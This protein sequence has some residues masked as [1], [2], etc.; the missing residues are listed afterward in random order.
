[1]KTRLFLL[2]IFFSSKSL[3]ALIP[4]RVYHNLP[5]SLGL[6]YIS[7]TIKVTNKISLKSWEFMQKDSKMPF[8]ILSYG[9]AG[10]MSYNLY[11]AKMFFQNGY[12]VIMYD[13]RGFGESSDFEMN[14]NMLYYKEFEED[15]KCV[16]KDTKKKHHPK[17]IILYGL[18]MGNM[19]SASVASEDHSVS[20]LILD[21]FIQDPGLVVKR[22]YS[23]KKKD[24]LLPE[25]SANY[26]SRISK[27][28]IPILLFSGLKDEVTTTEDA[29][30]ILGLNPK[31][32]LVTWDCNHL[33]C[34]YEMTKTN[35]GDL[36]LEKVNEFEMKLG[37][38]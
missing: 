15:L 7:N 9:D 1:M 30:R 37:N 11:Q 28:K 4:D 33:K 22:I 3:F 29:K 26:K 20:N 13:Y 32:E 36:Y 8:V 2:L 21:S 25:D 6:K 16:L 27:I 10:N 17:T 18:S 24:I 14:P 34:F 23:Y 5:E 38:L 12:N 19:I 31:S 35:I